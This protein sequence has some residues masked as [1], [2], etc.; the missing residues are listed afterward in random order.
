MSCACKLKNVLQDWKR[1]RR[2]WALIQA[3]SNSK[4]LGVCSGVKGQ[5]SLHV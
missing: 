3:P 2:N 1:N 5:F 4:D